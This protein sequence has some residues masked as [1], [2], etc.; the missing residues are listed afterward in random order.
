MEA[1]TFDETAEKSQISLALLVA[2][3]S[4]TVCAKNFHVGMFN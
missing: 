2:I 4:T 3:I 1:K